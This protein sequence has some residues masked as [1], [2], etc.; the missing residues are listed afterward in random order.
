MWCHLFLEDRGITFYANGKPSVF[1]EIKESHESERDFLTESFSAAL[2]NACRVLRIM[3]IRVNYCQPTLYCL[4]FNFTNCENARLISSVSRWP[5]QVWIVWSMYLLLRSS[6]AARNL[7][8]SY[9][10]KLAQGLV[11]CS[12]SVQS[13][14]FCAFR[15]FQGKL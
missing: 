13:M 10:G 12:L 9:G 15:D 1:T 6:E 8:K 5:S 14:S 2:L 7:T 11:L 4:V 3:C